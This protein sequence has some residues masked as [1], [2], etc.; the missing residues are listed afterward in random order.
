MFYGHF[1]VSIPIVQC[2]S[3]DCNSRMCSQ[4]YESSIGLGFMSNL[5]SIKLSQYFLFF[6]RVGLKKDTKDSRTCPLLRFISLLK[7]L[8]SSLAY[9]LL[10]NVQ[11]FELSKTRALLLDALTSANFTFQEALLSP[12]QFGI[13]NSRTRYYLM[14]KRNPRKFIFTTSDSVV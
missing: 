8:S 5:T 4:R 12:N 7:D 1:S 11:G 10:E 3:H 14:A 6:F 2:L 9:I 13:P